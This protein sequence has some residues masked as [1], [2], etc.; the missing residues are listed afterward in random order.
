MGCNWKVYLVLSP[1]DAT[2][3]T[4]SPHGG[5]CK[6]VDQLLRGIEEH[7]SLF[8]AAK[9]LKMAYSHAWA[10]LKTVQRDLGMSLV[11]SHGPH[12]SIVTEEGK[13]MIRLYEEAHEKINLAEKEWAKEN[14][15]A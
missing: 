6:G 7:G 3:T 13:R 9:N 12:G 8:A 10:M 11:E 14:S 15:L 2:V 4:E 1:N 5:Y